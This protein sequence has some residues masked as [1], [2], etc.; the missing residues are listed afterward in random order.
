M[1]YILFGALILV[2]LLMVLE[3]M[4]PLKV[5]LPRQLYSLPMLTTKATLTDEYF[6]DVTLYDRPRQLMA[7]Y[8]KK[9]YIKLESYGNL[10][11]SEEYGL[12]FVPRHVK[13]IRYFTASETSHL[14]FLN[15]RNLYSQNTLLYNYSKECP[16]IPHYN[17]QLTFR[18]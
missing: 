7:E 13:Q 8:A 5:P 2:S 17:N 3:A 12:A 9:G 15:A 10:F 11:V 18:R 14:S 1:S 4:K 6:A 16:K